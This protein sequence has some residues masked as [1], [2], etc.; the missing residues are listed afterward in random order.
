LDLRDQFLIRI[1]TCKFKL[2]YQTGISIETAPHHVVGGTEKAMEHKEIPP[3]AFLDIK[4][5]LSL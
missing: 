1:H 2:A 3:G 5:K 4:V